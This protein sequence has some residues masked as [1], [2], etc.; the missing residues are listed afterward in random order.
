MD[1]LFFTSVVSTV[2]SRIMYKQ[3][4]HKTANST[5]RCNL[6]EAFLADRVTMAGYKKGV[7]YNF[8]LFSVIGYDNDIL[9]F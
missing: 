9:S 7:F 3:D 4:V 5:L 2:K 8:W 1:G 6:T